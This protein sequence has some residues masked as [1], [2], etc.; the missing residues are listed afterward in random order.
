VNVVTAASARPGFLAT[1]ASLVDAQTANWKH[2]HAALTLSRQS[3]LG[4]EG[5]AHLADRPAQVL[6]RDDRR[7]GFCRWEGDSRRIR[8]PLRWLHKSAAM[9]GT[10]G[11]DRSAGAS[12]LFGSNPA[13]LAK[14][15]HRAASGCAAY[16][17]VTRLHRPIWPIARVSNRNNLGSRVQTPQ[18]IWIAC[19][20]G[21]SPL[22]GKDHHRSVN[23]IR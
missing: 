2:R 11:D 10:V 1:T 3:H 18:V 14:T 4:G 7:L 16:P 21:G 8:T 9:P 6:L 17:E 12:R 23:H 19:N 15:P 13:R 22:P 5:S 20:D